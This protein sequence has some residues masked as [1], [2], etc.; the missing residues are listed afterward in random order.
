[1]IPYTLFLS[2][3]PEDFVANWCQQLPESKMP[4]GSN[5]NPMADTVHGQ[6]AEM[7][8]LNDKLS[9]YI[10][11]VRALKKQG[12]EID[13]A[14]YHELLKQLEEE[15]MK[16]KGLYERE[17]DRL[18]WVL[19]S[20]F[21]L[22]FFQTLSLT[23]SVPLAAIMF[24]LGGHHCYLGSFSGSLYRNYPSAVVFIFSW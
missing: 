19:N 4:Y 17:L 6:K 15:L 18:R 11:K 5:S 9:D 8:F 16:T 23:V 24:C 14:K 2:Y 20:L 1:M 3:F 21:L 7:Q 10:N 13:P 22:F 12:S